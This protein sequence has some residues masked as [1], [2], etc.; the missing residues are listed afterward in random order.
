ME[1]HNQQERTLSLLVSTSDRNFRAE[2]FT[3]LQMC[4]RN[5]LSFYNGFI[6]EKKLEKGFE[7]WLGRFLNEYEKEKGKKFIFSFEEL[8]SQRENLRF[9]MFDNTLFSGIFDKSKDLLFRGMVDG[10]LVE[11]KRK[12]KEKKEPMKDHFDKYLKQ[13]YYIC[14][15]YKEGETDNIIFSF[16]NSSFQTTWRGISQK[17]RNVMEHYGDGKDDKE[18]NKNR[19]PI[20]IKEEQLILIL[21]LLLPNQ[22]EQFINLIK[23]YIIFDIN[24]I[25]KDIEKIEKDIEKSDKKIIGVRISKEEKE[26]QKGRK[27]RL[28]NI[29]KQV[30]ASID[31]LKEKYGEEKNMVFKYLSEIREKVSNHQKE[32]SHN[33]NTILGKEKGVSKNKKEEIINKN[34]AIKEK[35]SE[36]EG[37]LSVFMQYYSFIGEENFKNMKIFFEKKGIKEVDI[38]DYIKLNQ[39]DFDIR[40]ILNKFFYSITPS[41]KSSYTDKKVKDF[42]KALTGID[43]L[44]YQ[45]NKENKKFLDRVI[46]VRN[47]VAHNNPVY[48]SFV[49]DIEAVYKTMYL[50]KEK[51]N[52]KDKEE[53]KKI[54]R[55]IKE[56]NNLYRRLEDLFRKQNYKE[57]ELKE[58]WQDINHKGEKIGEVIPFNTTKLI[59]RWHTKTKGGIME[60]QEDN[61]WKEIESMGLKFYQGSGIDRNLIKKDRIDDINDKLRKELLKNPQVTERDLKGG[62]KQR[63]QIISKKLELKR[64]RKINRIVCEYKKS[65]KKA[66]GKDK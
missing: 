24:K 48:E 64:D 2:F 7:S 15:N 62:S 3:F 30:Q 58:E 46:K 8:K 66:A 5:L 29:K 41:I 13:N 38:N 42:G 27:K 51:L 12:G 40:L 61:K 52:P 25:E 23:N 17:I 34:Q 54:N 1:N 26:K 44:N 28:E 22:R 14:G 59:K 35:Y 19:E 37:R 11:I 9:D 32:T 57:L 56:E 6:K 21:S 50:F 53:N 55:F 60:L 10:I 16:K 63:I 49:N 65:L 39:L 20:A 45:E 43:I 36:E 18:K 47:R 4:N 31:I 33:Q